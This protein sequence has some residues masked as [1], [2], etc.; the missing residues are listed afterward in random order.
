MTLMPHHDHHH[1]DDADDDDAD[2]DDAHG[3]RAPH[4]HEHPMSR[5]ARCMQDEGNPHAWGHGL[6]HTPT[7]PIPAIFYVDELHYIFW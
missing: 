5:G 4:E 7:I 6:S 1:H 2:D 3:A